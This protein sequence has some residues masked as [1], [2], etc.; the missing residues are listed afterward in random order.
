MVLS[1]DAH[2]DAHCQHQGQRYQHKEGGGEQRAM[3]PNPFL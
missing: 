3:S 2:R 1:D